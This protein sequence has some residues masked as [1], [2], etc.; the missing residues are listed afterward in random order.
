ML[1][2]INDQTALDLALNDEMQNKNLANQILQGIAKYPFM[3]SGNALVTGIN[4]AF[5]YSVP[6]LG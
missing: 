6:Y 2:D 1:Q 3:H 5:K 4:K